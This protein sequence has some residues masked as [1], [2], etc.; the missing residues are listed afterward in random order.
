MS[1]LVQIVG[2][3]L[4]LIA[5]GLGQ[6]GV[7]SQTARSYLAFNLVGA[8]ILAVDAYLEQQWGFLL[9]EAVW[10]LIAGWSL[11]RNQQGSHPPTAAR[12]T[13]CSTSRGARS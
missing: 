12:R 9:L 6:A 7:L 11:A 3:L 1:P 5:F 8:S 10:A 4:I 13:R 2:A